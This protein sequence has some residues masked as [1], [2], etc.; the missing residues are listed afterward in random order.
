MTYVMWAAGECWGATDVTR[1][2]NQELGMG[3]V[4]SCVNDPAM[5]I[6]DP[7]PIPSHQSLDDTKKQG[8]T[9]STPGE[10]GRH[11]RRRVLN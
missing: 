1:T 10:K 3:G 4:V 5:D 7:K 9:W 8:P 11:K 6:K 2:E